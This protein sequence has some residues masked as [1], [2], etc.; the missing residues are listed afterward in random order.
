[1]SD[2]EKISVSNSSIGFWG[3]LFIVLITLKLTKLA[4]ITW[5]AIGCVALAP[6]ALFIAIFAICAMGYFVAGYF[7][8]RKR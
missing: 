2:K 7:L 4:E 8:N 6:V 3:L 5:L 1:M